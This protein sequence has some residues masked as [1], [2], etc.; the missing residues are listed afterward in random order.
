M[1]H[2]SLLKVTLSFADRYGFKIAAGSA[3][4]RRQLRNLRRRHAA[5]AQKMRRGEGRSCSGAV[6][7]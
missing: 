2:G 5:P 4:A 3:N 6:H 1:P 7:A